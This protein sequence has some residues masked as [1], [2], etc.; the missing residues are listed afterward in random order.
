MLKSLSFLGLLGIMVVVGL[1]AENA[2]AATRIK[3]ASTTSTQNSGLFDYLLPLFEKTKPVP[4][5]V[6]SK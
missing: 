6:T 4:E 1:A 5:R 2:A 3:C